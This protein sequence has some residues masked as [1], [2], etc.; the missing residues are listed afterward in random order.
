MSPALE[1]VEQLLKQLP[2][3]GYRSA[4]RIALHLLVE[5]PERL[6]PL[7]ASLQA[8]STA[9]RRC[10]VTGNLTEGETCAIYAD[11]ARHQEV[12]CVV[13]TVPDLMAIERSGVFRGV[14]HVLHGKLSP[15]HGVG[16][17]Q[18]NFASLKKR[19]A[20][21]EVQE[22]ILALSNDIE[23]EATCHYIQD[24]LLAG[25]EDIALSRIGFGLP[26]GGGITYA[27]S[28]TLRSALDGRR[29]F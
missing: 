7:I 29:Q 9:L 23:G 11:P 4:E 1:K 26:S 21:G 20:E 5:K 12:T 25:R 13:E 24:E 3:L 15:L 8:A 18:L 14:Y 6:G 2:G 22:V 16:P 28:A 19:I 27:D 17:D 10:P